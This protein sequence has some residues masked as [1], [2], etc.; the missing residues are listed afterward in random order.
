MSYPTIKS[1]FHDSIDHVCS[2]LSSFVVRPGKDLTRSRKIPAQQLLPFL[3]SMGSSSTRNELLDFWDMSP[4][5]PSESA[6]V[7]QRAK[8]KPQALEHLFRHFAS[9]LSSIK[10]PHD[11]RYLA[12]DGSSFTFFS[13]PGLSGPQYLVCGGHSAKGY[14]SLH[15]NA[16]YDLE[17]RIYTDALLQPVHDKDEFRAFCSIVDR[18]PVSPGTKN[19]YIGDR[20]YCSY[21]NMAHVIE[22]GQY[23]LFRTK[24]IHSKGLVGSFVF[25]DSQAFDITV[26]VTLVR[27]HSKKIHVREGCYRRFVDK[28]ASFDFIGY[29]SLD[30]YSLSFR[31]VRFPLQD[32]SYECVVTNLPR[33]EFPPERLERLY[34]ARWGIETSFRKLKYTVGLSNFHS[35]KPE[36]IQ[37]EIWARLTTYNI[38]EALVSRVILE[39]RGTK[40]E[41]GVN[42][43][44]AVHIC[45]VSLRPTTKGDP[46]DVMAL[47]RK[48]LVP[49]RKG[50]KYARL[51]TAH[52]RKPR[53]FIYRAA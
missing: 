47:L 21:N 29:G 11:Y 53:Y 4:T 27:S 31:V 41:Y 36:F 9:S 44:T 50:R 20:G 10:E 25:P 42:F 39:K 17:K 2:N 52:F 40:H 28:A 49:I 3:V 24:D 45:R 5:A 30:T 13:K 35:K 34:E 14:Y 7:Q 23:F 19:V 32:S 51:K 37:Q 6:L 46:V 8:L 43:T 26:D 38:T 18:H 1:L 22:N 16:F 12:A 15:L 48:E 33:E